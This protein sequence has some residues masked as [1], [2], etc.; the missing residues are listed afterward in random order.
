MDKTMKMISESFGV[1]ILSWEEQEF[2]TKFDKISLI[3]SKHF[4]YYTSLKFQKI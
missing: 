3:K 4:K 1:S 2:S